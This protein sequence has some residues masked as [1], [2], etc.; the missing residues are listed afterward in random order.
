MTRDLQHLSRPSIPGEPTVLVF[1]LGQPDN[2][3]LQAAIWKEAQEEMDI[4]QGTFLDTYHRLSYKNIM[5]KLWASL[6]CNQA[7]FV[8]KADDDM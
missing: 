3:S 8:V 6:Y 7:E 5:G 4:V 1:L 2:P